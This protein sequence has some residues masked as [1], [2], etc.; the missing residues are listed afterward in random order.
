MN[1]LQTWQW[2]GPDDPVP[3]DHI[4]QAGAQG[5]VSSL[6]HISTG[7]AWSLEEILKRKQEIEGENSSKSPLFWNVVESVNVHDDIKV[8]A[9]GYERYIRNYQDTLAAL[10]EAGVHTVCYNF[11]PL[12]DWT[13]TDLSMQLPNGARA[14]GF[15]ARQVCRL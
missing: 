15:D 14:L 2:F 9:P 7:E 10:G 5:I 11:M 6:H 13:R 8:R 3:L 12:I 4:R 1:M